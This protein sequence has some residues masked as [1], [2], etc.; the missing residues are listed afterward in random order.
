MAEGFA[1]VLILILGFLINAILS[2]N[3]R[4]GALEILSSANSEKVRHLENGTLSIVPDKLD[5][6]V[7]H[8]ELTAKLSN[9]E[10]SNK[11]LEAR[12]TSISERL[13]VVSTQLDHLSLQDGIKEKFKKE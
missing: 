7:K 5:F 10:S 4:V 8:A 12:V 11:V 9:V 13:F 6:V 1:T 3:T 2:I